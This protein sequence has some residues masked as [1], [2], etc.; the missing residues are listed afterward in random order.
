MLHLHLADHYHHG[1]SPIHLLDPRVKLFGTVAFIVVV[2]ALPFGKW[3]AY[4]ALWIVTLIVA[5]ASGLGTGFALRRS[6]VAL[7]FALAALTLPFTVPGQ[8]LAQIGGFT[9]SAEG[10][11]RLLSIVT[12]SWISVQMAILLTYT[13]EFQALLWAMRALRLPNVLVSI[14]GF[15]YRYLFVLGDEALRL[16]RARAARSGQAESGPSGG[17]LA[18]RGKVAGGMVGNLALRAFERSERIHDAMLARGFTGEIKT[19][20]P[21][22]LTA[23][24]WNGLIGWITLLVLIALMGWVF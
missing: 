5:R 16:M 8:P 11:T 21:P 7:P 6:Y 15:M 9:V 1:H 20:H 23:R 22:R 2:A 4:G 14:V 10:L 19:L 12:K 13:T 3:V 24:D 17:R 18:W